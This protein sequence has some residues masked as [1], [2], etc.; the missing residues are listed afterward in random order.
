M[1]TYKEVIVLIF[2]IIGFIIILGLRPKMHEYK[3]KTNYYGRVK[4]Q[5][6]KI[7]TNYNLLYQTEDVPF[8]QK[9][10][11][12]FR[13]KNF[14]IDVHDSFIQKGHS[15]NYGSENF[16]NFSGESQSIFDFSK[17][18]QVQDVL[19]KIQDRNKPMVLYDMQP[20]MT[21]IE[22][23]FQ[24]GDK[25]VKHQIINVL[26]EIDSEGLMCPTGVVTRIR[27]ASF[28]N[29][30]EKIPVTKSVL[31]QQMLN[32]AAS[33]N[34]EFQDYSKTKEALLNHYSDTYP[35]DQIQSIIDEWNLE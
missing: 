32:K 10:L 18:K 34:Q 3:I 14:K 9:E 23:T 26:K 5:F 28:I 35:T 33:L 12:T 4:H 31:Q 11:K 13:N 20:E 30:P 15:N 16:T 27:E 17:D 7:P 25:N 1:I 29:E 8:I 2:V 19:K 6:K 22:K 24:N 21:V